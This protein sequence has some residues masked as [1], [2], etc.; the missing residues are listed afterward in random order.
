MESKNKKRTWLDSVKNCLD[1]ISYTIKNEPNFLREILIGIVVI[2]CGFIFKINPTEWIIIVLLIGFVLICELINTA[3]EKTVDL[4]TKEYNEIA[5]IIKDAASG[6][7]LTT[8]ITSSIVGI[9]IFLPK[10]IELIK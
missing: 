5:K 4:Y 1:G 3:L 8:C 10:I 6:A 2:I 7:V 9:I